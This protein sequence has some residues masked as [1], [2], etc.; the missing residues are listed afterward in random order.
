MAELLNETT[1]ANAFEF[2]PMNHVF[3]TL[4]SKEGKERV[5][6]WGLDGLKVQRFK[7]NG[8]FEPRSE[9]DFLKEFVTSSQFSQHL[10]LGSVVSLEELSSFDLTKLPCSV[11]NMAHFDFLETKGL[12]APNGYLRKCMND[13]IGGVDIDTL[14][15][16][17][18][19]NEES[20]YAGIIDEASKNEFI[21]QVFHL[22]F[23]GGT[24]HQ[25]DEHATE[26]LEQ[27][28]SLYKEL[29][30]VHKASASGKI[31]ITSKVYLIKPKTDGMNASDDNMKSS[32]FPGVPE[33]CRCFVIIDPVKKYATTVYSNFK[34][35]W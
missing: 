32:L 19:L 9:M 10:E 7:F 1:H 23:I 33:H 27:T 4:E 28:K 15:T 8:R 18:L 5:H 17:W 25:R 26:Y 6:R 22:L 35:F 21:T 12:V 2:S 16:D 11:L 24:M 13:R 20:E 14:V 31:E 3:S 34:S 30:T 29:L